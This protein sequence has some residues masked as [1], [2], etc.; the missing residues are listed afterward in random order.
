MAYF[1]NSNLETIFGFAKL[2]FAGPNSWY[3]AA[4]SWFIAEICVAIEILIP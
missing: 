2:A 3:S 1:K 4:N